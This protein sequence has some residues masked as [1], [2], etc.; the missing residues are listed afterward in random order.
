MANTYYILQTATL[1][2]WLTSLRDALTDKYGD[3]VSIDK[4][5]TSE[6]VFT[7]P[8]IS[9]KSIRM[10]SQYFYYGTVS[11]TTFTSQKTF[12]YDHNSNFFTLR[13]LVLGDTFLL[14]TGATSVGDATCLIAKTQGEISICCYG[15]NNSTNTNRYANCLFYD[16]T[17]D[18][19]I[20]FVDFAPRSCFS[21]TGIPYKAN[22]ILYYPDEKGDQL[23]RK[24]DDSPDTIDGIYNTTRFG[25]A[26]LVNGGLF[27]STNLYVVG[28]AIMLYSSLLAE[29]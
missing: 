10:T 6:I 16:A 11:G 15:V 19:N 25:G 27:S 1:A 7:C 17:N 24:S 12:G 4:F 8:A 3:G 28:G 5:S 13:Y 21:D 22:V 18:K 14:L 2:D 20:G 26:L 9:E 23:L 29:F